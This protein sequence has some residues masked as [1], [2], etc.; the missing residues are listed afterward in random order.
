MPGDPL[1][2]EL[3]DP[4]EGRAQ[5]GLGVGEGPDL[6]A[7]RFAWLPL[8]PEGRALPGRRGGLRDPLHVPPR[9]F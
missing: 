8:K 3:L 9:S 6:D 5:L 7:L 1:K 2:E 4:G